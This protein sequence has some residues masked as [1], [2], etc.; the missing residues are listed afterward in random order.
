MTTIFL[1]ILIIQNPKKFLRFFN[2]TIFINLL[3][4]IAHEDEIITIY[5]SILLIKKLV[6]FYLSCLFRNNLLIGLLSDMILSYPIVS[7]CSGP[8]SYQTG[9]DQA[10]LVRVYLMIIYLIQTLHQLNERK[11]YHLPFKITNRNRLVFNKKPV[12][13]ITGFSAIGYLKAYW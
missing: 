6:K 9:W 12:Q 13:V 8:S 1:S 3:T 4:L 5:G 2:R 7:L 11:I 10:D